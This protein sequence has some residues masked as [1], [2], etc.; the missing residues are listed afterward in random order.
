M[1]DA[2]WSATKMETRCRH[3]G[4]QRVCIETPSPVGEMQVVACVSC[5][6]PVFLNTA[7]PTPNGKPEEQQ[8]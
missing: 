4:E 6:G 5:D 7:Q 8:L 2:K 1:M 3:C